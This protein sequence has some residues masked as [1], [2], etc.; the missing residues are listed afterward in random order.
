M[1]VQ[2]QWESSSH[3]GAALRQ[4]Y[5]CSLDEWQHGRIAQNN[6]RSKDVYRYPL[7]STFFLEQ[8]MSEALE[9]HNGKLASR[10]EIL[11]FCCLPMT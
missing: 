5:T 11:P 9:E 6:S 10:A 8:I 2:Y 1:E 3:H 4:G 7:F